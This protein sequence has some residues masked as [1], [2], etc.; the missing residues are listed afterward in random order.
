MGLNQK[1]EKSLEKS[2]NRKILHVKNTDRSN[3]AGSEIDSKV[4]FFDIFGHS[5]LLNPVQRASFIFL[6]PNRTSRTQWSSFEKKFA[7]KIYISNH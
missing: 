5:R 3:Q 7:Q 2:L 6:P 1:L 4:K